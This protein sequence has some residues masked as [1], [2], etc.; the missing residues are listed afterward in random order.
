MLQYRSRIYLR[1]ILQNASCGHVLFKI[2]RSKNGATLCLWMSLYSLCDQQKI[3]FLSVGT[4]I[5]ACIQDLFSKLLSLAF[6]PFQIGV[7]S[8]FKDGHL[9]YALLVVSISIRTELSLTAIFYHLRIMSTTVLPLLF[10][11]RTPVD[12]TGPSLFLTTWQMKKLL[13][14]G[15]LRKVLIATVLKMYRDFLNSVYERKM[16]IQGT[17]CICSLFCIRCRISYRSNTFEI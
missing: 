12:H 4:V 15:G 7:V 8:L 3:G 5:N 13:G 17:R 14:C 2:G 11:R 9:L 1:R 10:Y 16:C 6:K